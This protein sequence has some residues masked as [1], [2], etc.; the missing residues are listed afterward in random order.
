[1]HCHPQQD[2]CFFVDIEGKTARS[3]LGN[4]G[5]DVWDGEP[6]GAYVPV[7]AKVRIACVQSNKTET[8]IAGAKYDKVLEP[9]DVRKAEID[10]VQYGSDTKLKHI[11][12][13]NT[14][15]AQISMAK[16]VDCL[17]A[18]VY[19]QLGREVGLAFQVTSMIQIVFRMRPGM[20]KLIISRFKPTLCD[21]G[22]VRA[23]KGR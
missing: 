2:Y 22:L 6:E 5:I 19:L 3:I 8:F 4:R 7:G 20:M 12:K 17:S 23:S 18:L 13:S 1:M 14:F 16:S 10:L 9:F 21:S 15:W 11:G